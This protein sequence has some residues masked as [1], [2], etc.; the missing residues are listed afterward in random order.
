MTVFESVTDELEEVD[1][2][3]AGGPPLP[4]AYQP[5]PTLT[6]N[7]GQRSLRSR[8]PSRTG[9]SQPVHSPGRAWQ[10]QLQ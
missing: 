10:E 5:S 7:R 8:S 2:L 3:I 6:L 4:S 1:I 9:R